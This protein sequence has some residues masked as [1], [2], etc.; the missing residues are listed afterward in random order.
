MN[1]ISHQKLNA[2]HLA[3]NY[4]Y[5][6][7]MCVINCPMMLKDVK[8]LDLVINNLVSRWRPTDEFQAFSHKC[9]YLPYLAV[10]WPPNRKEQTNLNQ[11]WRTWDQ[12]RTTS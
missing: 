10:R 2:L 8:V 12:R 11:Q 1:N 5:C 7:F 6:G 4:T 3:T 9:V